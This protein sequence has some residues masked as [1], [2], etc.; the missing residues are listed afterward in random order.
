MFASR[1]ILKASPSMS[2]LDR[3][4]TMSPGRSLPRPR[5]RASTLNRTLSKTFSTFFPHARTGSFSPTPS[6]PVCPSTGPT[7]EDEDEL[8]GKL[9]MGEEVASP[10]TSSLPSMEEVPER[11]EFDY[12]A[13]VD[14]QDE[15]VLFCDVDEH[16]A[17]VFPSRPVFDRIHHPFAHP[18][19][20][21]PRPSTSLGL[22]SAV[23]SSASARTSFLSPNKTL[24]RSL[25]AT[26]TTSSF[27]PSGSG[28][29]FSSFL[30]A[31]RPSLA[32]SF[33]SRASS[34]RSTV[35][36]ASAATATGSGPGSDGTRSSGW[37]F[38]CRGLVDEDDELLPPVVGLSDDV[39]EEDEL[40][41]R[42][43]GEVVLL[44]DARHSRA[45][46]PASL[47]ANYSPKFNGPASALVHGSPAASSTS[48]YLSSEYYYRHPGPHQL[49]T[50]VPRTPP[51]MA[52][53]SK[54]LY[55][56][57]ALAQD[58]DE[59]DDPYYVERGPSRQDHHGQSF[60]STSSDAS[61]LG[62]VG[63]PN[64]LCTASALPAHLAAPSRRRSSSLRWELDQRPRS[65]PPEASPRGFRARLARS[66]SVA[67]YSS[68][69]LSGRRPRSVSSLSRTRWYDDVSEADVPESRRGSAIAEA[70]EDAKEGY[71]AVSADVSLKLSLRTTGS[72]SGQSG[73]GESDC[74]FSTATTS[75]P[76]SSTWTSPQLMTPPPLHP[77][78]LAEGLPAGSPLEHLAKQLGVVSGLGVSGEA[79]LA[80]E[81]AQRLRIG[82][83][84][85]Q[86]VLDF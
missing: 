45:M 54:H 41:P 50:P 33:L 1:Q 39:G 86:A 74:S 78:T 25:S 20:P 81:A 64:S 76:S 3:T 85:D 43:T 37:D 51:R 79:T 49:A 55:E 57:A 17:L 80:M 28:L 61:A 9:S 16:G 8:E 38:R 47:F 73:S 83:G 6:S 12:D 44:D 69:Y 66:R 14:D 68:S 52:M 2:T 72:I 36:G 30:F 53:S 62:L 32:D 40:P 42:H 11:D 65:F 15:A 70:S 23:G 35:A 29:G 46:S 22:M 26:S 27:G 34:G 84:L 58:L 59:S 13:T 31:R 67:S 7:T 77:A 4:A 5:A 24:M 10:A 19:S 56:L 48:S 82:L 63:V 60:L 18:T 71:E 75:L 21:P